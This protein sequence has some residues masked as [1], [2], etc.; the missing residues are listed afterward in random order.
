[1][2]SVYLTM[3]AVLFLL[4]SANGRAGAESK[5]SQHAGNGACDLGIALSEGAERRPGGALYE[6]PPTA[7]H[8]H[9]KG[10][11]DQMKGAHM[12]HRP[13]HGGAFYMAGNMMHHLEIIFSE[14]CG[15]SVVFYNAHTEAIRADRFHAFLTAVPDD[16]SEAEVVRILTPAKDATKLHAPLGQSISKPFQIRLQVKFPGEVEPQLFTRTIGAERK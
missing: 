1:M 9:K 3:F 7:H 5:H 2:K 16:E 6:K 15:F 10:G 4:L 14:A 12:R 13:Q 11:T 8:G